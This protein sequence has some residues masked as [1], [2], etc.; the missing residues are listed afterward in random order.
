MNQK[1]SQKTG[2][3]KVA[4]IAPFSPFEREGG[5]QTYS[6]GLAKNLSKLN[7]EIHLFVRTYKKSNR[8]V[9][10]SP[11]LFIHS[12]PL[13]AEN[14]N[15][16]ELLNSL[17]NLDYDLIHIVGFGSGFSFRELFLNKKKSIKTK[18][19]QHSPTTVIS[20]YLGIYDLKEGFG[21][22]LR[23]WHPKNLIEF[24]IMALL[25]LKK[26]RLADTII[27]PSKRTKKEIM[28][29]YRIK[30]DK[31]EVIPY[32]VDLNTFK[33][34]NGLKNKKNDK[35]F[36]VLTVCRLKFRKGLPLLIQ[37]I[38]NVLKAIPNVKFKIVGPPHHG[39]VYEKLKDLINKR[40][41]TESVELLGG[42]S[43]KDIPY[44][45]NSSNIFLFPSIQEGFGIVLLEA[46]ACGKPVVAFDIE[47]INEVIINNV[48]GLLVPKYN[49]D[50][51]AN[52][53]VTLLKNEELRKKMGEMGKKCA[54]NYS[55]ELEASRTATLYKRI[56]K[57][58]DN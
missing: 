51:L 20:E 43:P 3:V 27:V 46:M 7:I 12:I 36:E 40:N 26:F 14:S 6:Y 1:I 42:V 47:P 55:C 19:I 21:L 49:T 32:G 23:A 30:K 45:Y 48:T 44:Y 8:V 13:D 25:D 24:V 4:I 39:Y 52:A 35:T 57:Y 2:R 38:P 31:I 41:L 17:S 54:K 34:E 33:T 29:W 9:Q 18:Y 50:A 16:L 53:V 15:H 22:K 11:S 28:R 5:L 10:E 58:D 37:C 56:L